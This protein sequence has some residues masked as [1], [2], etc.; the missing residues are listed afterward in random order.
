MT[1]KVNIYSLPLSFITHEQPTV[2][3]IIDHLN[4][5]KIYIRK[6]MKELKNQYNIII[7]INSN[8]CLIKNIKKNIGGFVIEMDVIF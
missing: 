2:I 5:K 3:S 4:N 7:D 6:I 8:I 1:I